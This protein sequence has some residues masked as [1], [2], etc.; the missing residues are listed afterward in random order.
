M[1]MHGYWKGRT[2]KGFDLDMTV[3][4]ALQRYRG[5]MGHSAMHAVVALAS[6]G[7][8]IANPKDPYQ[9]DF[10]GLDASLP[11]LLADFIGGAM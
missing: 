1:F 4:E 10:C 8:T 9:M 2:P 7:F 6:N 3:D 5:V 11:S